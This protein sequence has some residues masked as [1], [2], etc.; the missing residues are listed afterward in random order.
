MSLF[1]SLFKDPML[2]KN[3]L[4]PEPT[5]IN[6]AVWNRRWTKRK[7]NYN[8]NPSDET[9]EVREAFRQ[10]EQLVQNQSVPGFDVHEAVCSTAAA[11]SRIGTAKH[12]YLAEELL[13]FVKKIAQRNLVT[14]PSEARAINEYIDGCV[15]VDRA[16]RA[17]GAIEMKANK[18]FVALDKKFAAQSNKLTKSEAVVEKAFAG[19]GPNSD[20][21]YYMGLQGEKR[22]RKTRRNRRKSLR[23]RA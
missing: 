21:A 13:N 17:L 11:I 15:M 7:S 4:A 5:G 22:G 6:E 3:P 9:P 23:S 20:M 1:R 16:E 14:S 12:A 2:L 18:N 19:M 8:K 10:L